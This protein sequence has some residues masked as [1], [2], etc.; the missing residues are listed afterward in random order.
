VIKGAGA[1]L[2]LEAL[3][4][5]MLRSVVFFAEHIRSTDHQRSWRRAR[6]Y[7]RKDAWRERMA[8]QLSDPHEYVTEDTDRRG[9]DEPPAP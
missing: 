8:A 7:Y 2:E 3:E 9:L 1:E 6:E 4:E 5:P